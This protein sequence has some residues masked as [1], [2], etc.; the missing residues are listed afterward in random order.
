MAHATAEELAFQPEIDPAEAEAAFPEELVIRAQEGDEMAQ[1]ELWP[2]VK[3]IAHSV[4]WRFSHDP[5]T[6]DDIVTDGL[7]MV[8]IKGLQHRKYT[9]HTNF[10]GWVNRVVFNVAINHYKSRRRN[11][12]LPTDISDMR[13]VAA[14]DNT[15]KSALSEQASDVIRRLMTEAGVNPVFVEPF[16]LCTVEGRST[17]EVATILEINKNTL[18]TRIHRARRDFKK[19]YTSSSLAAEL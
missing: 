18:A 3:P 14:S 5:A 7:A 4:A 15:E 17:D 2:L 11:L 19:A 10:K 13:D 16:V 8:Y 1:V 12:C 6:I 9:P